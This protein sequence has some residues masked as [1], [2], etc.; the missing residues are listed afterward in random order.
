MT[1][2]E[3]W[4]LTAVAERFRVSVDA[5]ISPTRVARVVHAR[6]LG[7][8]L[9]YDSGHSLRDAAAAFGRTNHATAYHALRTHRQRAETSNEYAETAVQLRAGLR[10]LTSNACPTCGRP[11]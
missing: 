2:V 3:S 6:H 7:M 1:D 4:V 5:L 10:A 11:R 8:W 9:L